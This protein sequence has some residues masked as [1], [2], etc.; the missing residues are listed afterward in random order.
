MH[1]AVWHSK[2]RRKKTGGLRKPARS[3]KKYEK[4]SEPTY[5]RLSEKQKIKVSRR[6]GGN[7]KVRALSVQYANVIKDGKAE[8]VKI[9]GIVENK[10]NPHFIREKIITKGAIIE[11]EKG[12]ARVTSRPGQDGVVNAVLID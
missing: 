11:T 9:L 8:K 6:R 10:A 1:L 2:S 4:G 5:T 12:K 3:H 7:I